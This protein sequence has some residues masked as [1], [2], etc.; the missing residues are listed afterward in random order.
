MTLGADES[1]TGE[2]LP[3]AFSD[4]EC[5]IEWA[6]PTE[7][8]R[9]QKRMN[10][11]MEELRAFYDVVAPRAAQARDHLD[12]LELTRMSEPDQR[13]LWLLFSL[14]TVSFAVDV[15]GAPR[16]PDTGSAYATRVGEPPTFP[17]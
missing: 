13:L 7:R 14:I 6:I 2:G 16:V 9:Y 3:A 17:V 8:E 15:F 4:L 5:V 12:T 11:S 10:S 1:T